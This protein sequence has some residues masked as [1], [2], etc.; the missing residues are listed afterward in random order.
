MFPLH[1]GTHGTPVLPVAGA[2][3]SRA[4]AVTRESMIDVT[5]EILRRVD[6]TGRYAREDNELV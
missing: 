3:Y 1:F 5:L 2:E 4:S 6:P